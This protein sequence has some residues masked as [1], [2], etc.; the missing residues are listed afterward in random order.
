MVRNKPEAYTNARSV[1]HVKFLCSIHILT[2]RYA[3][4]TD[5]ILPSPTAHSSSLRSSEYAVKHG[6]VRA[7]HHSRRNYRAKQSGR[8]RRET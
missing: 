8:K 1:L 4:R 6:V 5:F 2:V 7:A 3:L